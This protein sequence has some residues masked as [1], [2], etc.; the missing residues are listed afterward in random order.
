MKNDLEHETLT[1]GRKFWCVRT[2]LTDVNNRCIVAESNCW[3][4]QKQHNGCR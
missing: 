1:V 3:P 2:A 4:A